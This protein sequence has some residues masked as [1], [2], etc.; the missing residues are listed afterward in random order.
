[1]LAAAGLI[2]LEEM[3]QRLCQDH[4]NARFLADCLSAI[5]GIRV[6]HEVQTNIVIFDVAGTGLSG[7]ELS[8]RL[9]A[10]GVLINAVRGTL[11]RLVTH[12]DAPRAD[13]ESA[14]ALIPQ[15]L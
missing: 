10:R 12:F 2:A 6:T 5:D 4:E 1:V 7:A 3:P 9:K 8:A 15:C 14:A 11:M 13:C